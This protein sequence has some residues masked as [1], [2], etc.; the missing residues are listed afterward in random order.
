MAQDP[1]ISCS[2]CVKRAVRAFAVL[3]GS[4]VACWC[5]CVISKPRRQELQSVAWRTCGYMELNTKLWGS[6]NRLF[7]FEYCFGKTFVHIIY[8]H[9]FIFLLGQQWAARFLHKMSG[10][11]GFFEK[12]TSQA[13]PLRQYL[14]CCRAWLEMQLSEFLQST[15]FCWL[16]GLPGLMWFQLW[17]QGSLRCNFFVGCFF[18]YFFHCFVTGKH[19]QTTS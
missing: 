4:I 9:V 7:S 15:N 3:P 10:H 12:N 8:L 18:A 5:F 13:Q 1:A 6:L 19:S 17:L 2:T 16:N 11:S 14:M